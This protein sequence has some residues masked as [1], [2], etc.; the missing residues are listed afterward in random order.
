MSSFK[1]PTPLYEY[2]LKVPETL[3]K[4]FLIKEAENGLFK[5]IPSLEKHF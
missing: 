2:L 5:K 3:E 1:L 4:F